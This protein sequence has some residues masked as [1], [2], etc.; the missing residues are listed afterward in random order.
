MP[1]HDI[2]KLASTGTGA[3]LTVSDNVADACPA[4]FEAITVYVVREDAAVACR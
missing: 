2:S 1:F 4:E 3:A